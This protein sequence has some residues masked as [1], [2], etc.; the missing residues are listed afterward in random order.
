MS[1]GQCGNCDHQGGIAE[2]KWECRIDGKLHENE[3]NCENFKVYIQ[4]KIKEERIQEAEGIKNRMEAQK[5]RDHAVEIARLNRKH[6]AE[7]AQINR[8]HAEEMQNRRM[9]FDSKFWKANWW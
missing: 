9:L 8:D 5:G 2:K 6:S 3:S 4:G 1:E 7:I